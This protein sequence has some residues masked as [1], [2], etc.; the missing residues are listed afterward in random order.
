MPQSNS[1]SA[2]VS[3]EEFNKLM[4]MLPEFMTIGGHKGPTL[5]SVRSNSGEYGLAKQLGNVNEVESAVK[6]SNTQQRE[7][8]TIAIFN[9][10]YDLVY[11]HENDAVLIKNK[12]SAYAYRILRPIEGVRLL[13]RIYKRRYPT[14]NL[15][16]RAAKALYETI[17]NSTER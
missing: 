14:T 11:A 1:D 6:V 17:C 4:A 2:P 5:T 9:E 12:G 8:E 7:D 3:R 15:N 13:S 10:L 16:S